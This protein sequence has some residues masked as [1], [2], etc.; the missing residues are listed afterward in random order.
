MEQYQNENDMYIVSEI[1]ISYKP[2]IKPAQRPLAK[3]SKDAYAIFKESWDENLIDFIEQFKVLLLDN[4]YKVLGIFTCSSGG[5]KFTIVDPRLIYV[6][7]LKSNASKIMVAHNHP[8]GNKTPSTA[9]KMIT[10]KLR[11]GAKL[12]DIELL[13]HLIITSEGFLS[14]SDE[15]LL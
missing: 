9:D 11:L 8:S 3:T 5:T 12:L 14:F 10:E 4:A 7:A 2:K 15:G 13:D 1:E 6:T